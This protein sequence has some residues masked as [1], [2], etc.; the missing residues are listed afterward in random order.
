M[1]ARKPRGRQEQKLIE[2]QTESADCVV[3]HLRAALRCADEAGMSLVA[4]HID[5]ALALALETK[6][7]GHPAR[8][9]TTSVM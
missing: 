2:D 8:P 6:A 5:H 1:R 4:C 7:A 3:Q 9:V